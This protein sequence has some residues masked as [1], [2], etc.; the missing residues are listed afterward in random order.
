MPKWLEDLSE[1]E[2]AV[3]T[4]LARD[5][6]GRLAMPREMNFVLYGFSQGED[7]ENAIQQIEGR[8]WVCSIQRQA[9]EPNKLLL[10]AT[11]QNYVIMRDSHVDD[12]AFFQRM[13][14]LHAVGYDGWFA[15]N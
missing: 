9:D 2:K 5:S 3:M 15:S 8:G 13:A 4:Q 12:K 14:N 6:K 1:P 10:T 11:K 7:L